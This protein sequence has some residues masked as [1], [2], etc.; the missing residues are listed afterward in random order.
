MGGGC[1]Y[2]RGSGKETVFWG[3]WRDGAKGWVIDVRAGNKGGAVR[4][5]RGEGHFAFAVGR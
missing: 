2:P 4:V 3:S 1:E 5:E